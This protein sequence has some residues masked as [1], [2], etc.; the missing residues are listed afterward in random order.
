MDDGTVFRAHVFLPEK[1]GTYPVIITLGPSPS[2]GW[3]RRAWPK[4]RWAC[5]TPGS[6]HLPPTGGSTMPSVPHAQSG[7]IGSRAAVC[8]SFHRSRSAHV[9]PSLGEYCGRLHN[10]QTRATA[11]MRYSERGATHPPHLRVPQLKDQNTPDPIAVS[12]MCWL[13]NR[14]AR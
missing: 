1:E 11:R 5:K 12:P 7:R 3:H 13:S 8:A 14:P 9:D 10:D 6:D 4:E 2:A